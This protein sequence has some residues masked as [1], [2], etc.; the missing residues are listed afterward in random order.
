MENKDS[1]K[2]I[3][4]NDVA[5]SFKK[6]SNGILTLGVIILI[7]L[8]VVSIKI[9]SLYLFIGAWGIFSVFVAN[10][11]ILLAVAEIIQKLQNIENNTNKNISNNEIPKL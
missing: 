4:T 8:I 9:E 11:L 2:K 10:S 6:W 1:E 3:Y 7:I 5:Y